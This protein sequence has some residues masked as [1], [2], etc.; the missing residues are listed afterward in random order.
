ME[1]DDILRIVRSA[2]AEVF[3]VPESD[4]FQDTEFVSD[5]GCESLDV[6]ELMFI[7]EE[8]FDIPEIQ[9]EEVKNIETVGDACD[10]ILGKL[11]K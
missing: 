8:E 6:T 7:A 9:A 5:L 1:Y 2:V 11:G 10:F 3:S 4:I